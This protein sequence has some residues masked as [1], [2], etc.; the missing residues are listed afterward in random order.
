MNRNKKGFTLIELIGVIV[1]LLLLMLLVT[2][3][4]VNYIRDTKEDAHNLQL[5]TIE[6]SAKNWASAKENINFLPTIDGECLEVTLGELKKSGYADLN[7]TNPK[8]NEPYD[9]SLKVVI[10]KAGNNLTYEINETDSQVCD[11]V[12]DATVPYWIYVGSDKEL[13]GPTGKVTIEVKSS[14]EVDT[15]NLTNE[16][17][18]VRVGNVIQENAV[19]NVNCNKTGLINCDI[20]VSNV[21]GNGSINLIIDKDTLVNKN[22]SSKVTTIYTD[23]K[24][25]TKGPEIAYK[26]REN[27]NSS[28]KYATSKD[29]VTLK[30]EATDQEFDNDALTIDDIKVY[31]NG[32]EENVTKVLNKKDITNGKSYELKISNM[33]SNGDISVVIAKDKIKDSLGNG[34][35]EK[36]I[37]P[38]ITVDN[39]LPVIS[40]DINGNNEFRVSAE[41]EIEA[42]DTETGINNNSLKYIWNT[43]QSGTG[44]KAYSNKGTVKL[45]KVTGSY[46]LIA[47]ACDN[48]GNCSKKISD[49]FKLSNEGP[50]ITLGTNGNSAYAQSASSKI[51]INSTTGALDNN[52]LLYIVSTDKNATPTISYVNN[53]TIKMDNL[54]G[55]YYLIVKACDEIGNCTTIVSKVFYLDNEA[56]T[57]TYGTN[58]NSAYSNTASSKITITDNNN[59]NNDTIKYIIST[60]RAA[61]PDKVLLN[62]ATINLGTITGSYYLVTNACDTAGNCTKMPSNVFYMD[63]VKPVITYGTN[64]NSTYA[65]NHSTTVTATDNLSTVKTLKYIISTSNTATPSTAIS[66]GVTVSLSALT[67]DYYVV[68]QA[69]DGAGNCTTLATKVFKMDNTGPVITY[70]TNGNSTY[71]KSYSTTITATDAHTSLKTLKYITGTSNTATPTTSISSGGKVTIS[72]VTGDYYVVSEACDTLGNCTT[73]ATKVFKMDNTVPTITYGTNGSS[74]YATTHSTTVTA[75]DSHSQVNTLKY[76]V[77][78][79]NTATPATAISSGGTVTLSNLSGKYYVVSQACDKAGN[80]KTLATNVFNID[81]TVPVITWSVS[82]STWTASCTDAHSGGATFTT[83]NTGTLGTSTVS[84]N[85]TC[86]D[87]VGNTVTSNATYTYSTCARGSANECRRT[88]WDCSYQETYQEPYSCTETY[89]YTGTCSSETCG[90][91]A[92]S[93]SGGSWY[94]QSQT[95]SSSLGCCKKSYSCE[96]TGTRTTTCYRDATRT[97]Q[98][99]CSNDCGYTVNTC[100]AGFLSPVKNY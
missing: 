58:G 26:G 9:D 33:T 95:T 46:Y 84:F 68:T 48:A 19:V 63:N 86:K 28:L 21:S 34:N 44:N 60:D 69:C 5:N 70:G 66:S 43:T 87:A 18:I 30:F 53:E 20:E 65:K 1:V 83:A 29:T 6:D 49:V 10:R 64:G 50:K 55:D 72:G 91:P 51:T 61:E 25:D 80:C 8:T 54:T 71:A 12:I 45:D 32:K 17:V 74:T 75:S 47:E 73:L 22:A 85:A 14:M 39:I 24:L 41:V 76:I 27:T 88:E 15:N 77:S 37:T 81:N 35:K 79:S 98:K 7:I 94:Q 56:P 92:S 40:F 2:P 62:G 67:G 82:G 36:V 52:S 42:K 38:G 11:T 57:V 100:Q 16:S 90:V 99:T 78:T 59:L 23:V 3:L 13:I 97:V 96:K 93:C 89:K 31:I 4:V